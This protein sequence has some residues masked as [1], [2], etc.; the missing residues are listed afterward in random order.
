MSRHHKMSTFELLAVI[1]LTLWILAGT[2]IAVGWVAEKLVAAARWP[3]RGSQRRSE[4]IERMVRGMTIFSRGTL[5]PAKQVFPSTQM[6]PG[7]I[8]NIQ[9]RFTVHNPLPTPE[10][11]DPS[12]NPVRTG[13]VRPRDGNERVTAR[14][15]TAALD[16]EKLNQQQEEAI[17]ALGSLGVRRIDAEKLLQRVPD[18]DTLPASALVRE[19]LRLRTK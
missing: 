4:A 12:T 14:Q 6:F 17:S 11:L 5:D 7:R 1:R 3:F 18:S 2:Y 8:G 13:T 10:R 19:M 16:A 15:V 9:T